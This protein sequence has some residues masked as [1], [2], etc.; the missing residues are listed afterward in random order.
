MELAL[1]RASNGGVALDRFGKSVR[2]SSGKHGICK[3]KGAWSLGRSKSGRGRRCQLARGWGWTRYSSRSTTAIPAWG[4][5]GVIGKIAMQ[6]RLSCTFDNRK[7]G[8]RAVGFSW[9][10]RARR[11]HA[12]LFLALSPGFPRPYHVGLGLAYVVACWP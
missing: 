11:V 1:P 12:W 10:E 6:R 4:V 2:S 7:E 9:S 3:R 5:V 8:E